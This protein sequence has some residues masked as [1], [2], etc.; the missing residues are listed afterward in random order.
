VW[1][2]RCEGNTPTDIHNQMM[3]GRRQKPEDKNTYGISSLIQPHGRDEMTAEKDVAEINKITAEVG[4]KED[5]TTSQAVLIGGD[6]VQ[7]SDGEVHGPVKEER[8]RSERLQ[9]EINLTTEDKGVMM[10]KNR[11]LEGTNLNDA[12]AFSILSNTNLISSAE[13]MGIDMGN[14]DFQV[15][16]VIKD[17][18]ISRHSLK[19]KSNALKMP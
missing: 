10:N 14:S 16:N 4:E 19:I 3:M 18:E 15:F 13:G 11:N 8:R 5:N 17:L 2:A 9:K 7:A 12:N 1:L 6:G